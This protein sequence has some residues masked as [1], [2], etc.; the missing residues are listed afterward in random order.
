MYP[1]ESLVRLW[2]YNSTNPKTSIFDVVTDSV[3]IGRS[4]QNDIV[5]ESSYVAKNAVQL[6]RVGNRWT[7]SCIGGAECILDNRTI[8]VGIRRR[9]H[10]ESEFSIFPYV[11]SF[12]P[13]SDPTPGDVGQSVRQASQVNAI[14]N[15]IHLAFLDQLGQTTNHSEAAVDE[16]FVLKIE[17][18]I[19]RLCEAQRVLED[20]KLVQFLAGQFIRG[21]LLESV[22]VG[23]DQH[24]LFHKDN[25]AVWARR[26]SAIPEYDRQITRIENRLA[27]K[28]NLNANSDLTIRANL[29][30]AH[31][32]DEWA[33]CLSNLLEQLLQY[34]A[35]QEV[36]KQLKDILFGYGPLED[37]LRTPT[38]DEI[39]V[40]GREQ[41]YIEKNGSIENSG[42][43]FI[44]DEILYSIIERIVSRVDRQIDKSNPLVDARLAD[45]SRVNAV[46]PP[47]AIGGPLLT[48]RKFHEKRLTI[49]QLVKEKKAITPE[50]VEFLEAIVRNRCNLLIAGGT[51]TGKTTLLNCLSQFIPDKERIVTIE[52]T[53]ELKLVKSHVCRM[54]CKV[55]NCEGEG[56]YKIRDLLVN[57]LRMRPDRIIVGECRGPEA[58]DMLQAMNTGHDGSMTTLHANSPQDVVLRLEV[59]VLSGADLPVSS[60]RQQIASAIDFVVQLKRL[61]GGRRVVSHISE[62]VGVDRKTGS[63]RLKDIF[64]LEQD[65]GKFVLA[66][67]GNLP[68]M[69]EKLIDSGALELEK[70]FPDE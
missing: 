1:G 47:I 37:L 56:S 10:E 16:V 41:I 9:L 21:K 31:Y 68:S 15:Q 61:P 53:A 13:V 5:L 7:L 8:P 12:K 46:I 26:I 67:T 4:P 38:I 65:N 2:Y 18:D 52:D 11:F 29:I 43:R 39:M 20:S 32:W 44:N 55:A 70:L 36:Q 50:A 49:D 64:L 6:D 63:V 59:L 35:V 23:N 51:G 69:M 62:I 28:L 33:I 25:R 57:S 58:L 22:F 34:L 24:F 60:I 48:I 66:P 30:D 17:N 40:V 19:Q 27:R 3:R 42:R 14:V 54:E 45:G